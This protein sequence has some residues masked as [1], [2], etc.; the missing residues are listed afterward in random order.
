MD[1]SLTGGSALST[2]N[3]FT[4]PSISTTT[5]YYI[6]CTVSGCTSSSRSSALATIT[7]IPSAATSTGGSNCGTGTVSMTASGCVE[8]RFRGMAP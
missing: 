5:T 8:V 6:D 7:T 4:T 2:G 1:G 3:N